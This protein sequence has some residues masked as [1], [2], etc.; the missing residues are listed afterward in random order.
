MTSASAE[1]GRWRASRW[2]SFLVLVMAL[3]VFLISWLGEQ[4]S[5]PPRR[6]VATP[7]YHLINDSSN[8]WLALQDPTLFALPH[9]HGFSGTNWLGIDWVDFK[10][11]DWTEP[12]RWYPLP[13]QELGA[14]FKS[15]VAHSEAP[16]FPGFKLPSPE[17]IAPDVIPALPITQPSS[18]RIEG[19]LAGRRL[20]SD[21]RLPPQPGTE[22]LTNSVV[23]LA[24]DA[25]GYT[26]SAVLLPNNGT[27]DPDQS[28]ADQYAL[29]LAERARFAAIPTT[30]NAVG[31]VTFGNMVFQWETVPKTSTN[32]P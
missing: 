31:D 16:H 18:L 19:P 30:G 32:S 26:F 28:R 13:V 1:P 17:W 12:P 25:R 15:F 21:F 6:V 5:V 14:G 3:Q 7:T 11:K 8:Q 4:T 24:V 2:G 9:L 20:L 23:Q 22:L 10:A 27:R 29:N